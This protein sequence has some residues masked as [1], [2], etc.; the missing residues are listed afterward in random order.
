MPVSPQD[1]ALWAS[2]TGRKYPQSPAEKA[3]LTPEVFNFVRNLPKTGLQ[4]EPGVL[5]ER[6]VYEKPI[7]VRH[8]DDNSVFTSPITPDN[9]VPKVAGTV[10][11]TMTSDH[12]EGQLIEN[13]E[14]KADSTNFARTAAKLALAAGVVA[15]GIAAARSPAV[16]GRVSEFLSQFGTP[17]EGVVDTVAASGDIT[18]QT[19]AQNY[20]QEVISPQTQIQQ[21]ARGAAPGTPL[22]AMDPTTTESVRVK[23][24]TESE[25]ITT[26]Q[27]FGP[28]TKS[29]G[30]ARYHPEGYEVSSQGDKR[31]SALYA[32]L[33]SGQTVEQAYQA[34]KGTGKGLPALDP[35]FDY[36]GTYK[37]LWN[38]FFNANP[39][40]L[41][42][43]AKASQG[44]VITDKFANTA[45]NQARA[46]HEILVERGLRGQNIA[47]TPGLGSNVRPAPGTPLKAMNPTTTESV[48]VK[49]MTESEVITTTQSFAPVADPWTGKQTPLKTTAEKVQEFTSQFSG[50]AAVDPWE[51]RSGIHAQPLFEHSAQWREENPR[52][53][54]AADQ[55][56]GKFTTRTG[57]GEFSLHEEVPRPALGGKGL[58]RT[59]GGAPSETVLVERTLSP[60]PEQRD[61]TGF[62]L[63]GNVQRLA[64]ARDIEAAIGTYG[65]QGVF[66]E[67]PYSS[68][69][70][71][72]QFEPVS[73]IWTA[74]S[75][76]QTRLVNPGSQPILDKIN[77]YLGSK[78]AWT[79]QAK[80][81]L[82]GDRLQRAAQ[83]LGY[84][85]TLKTEA[86]G[87]TDPSARAKAETFIK[88]AVNLYDYTQDPSVL[89]AAVNKSMPLS[90]T[91]PG[92]QT[93]ET[94][95]FFKPF[96]A[97]GNKP[98]A[99]YPMQRGVTNPVDALEN[100]VIG[101]QTVLGNIK[102]EI[103]SQFGLNPT[104]K[105]TG[106]MFNKLDQNQR[107]LLINASNDLKEAT[108]KYERA[109]DFQILYSIP[110][111]IVESKRVPLIS[112]E[113][114]QIV[115]SVLAPE[116]QTIGTPGYYQ[117]KAA[118]GAGRQE[119]GGVGRRREALESDPGGAG[120]VISQRGDTQLGGVISELEA[121]PFLY[122]HVDTGEL[123]QPGQ[124]PEAWI[125]SE[126]VRPVRGT[127]VEPQRIMGHEGRTFKGVSA[128]EIDPRSFDP[129]ERAALAKQYPSRVTPEGLIY[130]EQ[131]MGGREAAKQRAIGRKAISESG[132]DPGLGTRFAHRPA[133]PEGSP[134]AER[135]EVLRQRSEAVRR[136]LR[137]EQV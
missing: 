111:E 48:G 75:P 134:R 117:M 10:G 63:G 58:A 24:V 59:I 53:G 29:V 6:V 103:L 98:S 26:T 62:R 112:K 118:G 51:A 34:A 84:I 125:K 130:S 5:V 36:W 83:A 108:A 123:L 41:A 43:I 42:E 78:A 109:K 74:S 126:A 102:A 31:F 73:N 16:R 33:P 116:E 61:V 1:F 69:V 95:Q 136:I 54:G 67:G 18:P 91:F 44:K 2:A 37:G 100:V 25:V 20:N 55:P 122:R 87:M 15:G 81:Q 106:A 92:G 113:S 104:D 46:I 13:E 4:G 121:T 19:T 101:K 133:A 21:A 135:L 70:S 22:K 88:Q 28:K 72:E 120:F 38:E 47:T 137:G 114:G 132:A 35:N 52:T 85:E 14:D 90:L 39:Q 32:T 65:T 93:V 68:L 86:A 82:E 3:Q 17:R 131:A 127:A 30:Y 8:E 110:E 129:V 60:Y 76:T 27:S 77:D 64:G 96:G 80:S 23:P 11:N 107:K 94:R 79:E 115:G 97:T 49:P 9:H 99:D 45:N 105:I 50:E 124:V 12:Y 66:P 71:G 57:T 119:M 7:A 56:Y 40:A 128:T 89:E